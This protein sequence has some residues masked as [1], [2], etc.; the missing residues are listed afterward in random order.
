VNTFRLQKDDAFWYAAPCGPCKNRYFVVTCH[1]H[2]LGRNNPKHR[3]L[4]RLTRRHIPEDGIH[5]CHRFEN[6]KSYTFHF[7]LKSI[8]KITDIY[9]SPTYVSAHIIS[10]TRSL[11]VTEI[12]RSTFVQKMRCAVC[13]V[14]FSHISSN[15]WVIKK[16]K[17]F[18]TSLCLL[19]VL[20][21][22]SGSKN[23][24]LSIV[25]DQAMIS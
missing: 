21:Y 1:L 8:Q 3:F 12:F 20:V 16:G 15:S 10:V 25:A 19:S 22:L 23:S 13:P 14:H 6:L 17:T 18:E 9:G 5:H 2:L 24:G 7:W 11:F 4:T